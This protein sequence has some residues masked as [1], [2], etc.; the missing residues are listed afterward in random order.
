MCFRM[1]HKSLSTRNYFF[2]ITCCSE[3]YIYIYSPLSL[4]NIRS[5]AKIFVQH[6][7]AVF[8]WHL[9]NIRSASANGLRV[10]YNRS[11]SPGP[12]FSDDRSDTTTSKIPAV[13][14]E[15]KTQRLGAPTRNGTLQRFYHHRDTAIMPR[16]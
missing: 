15:N 6:F 2:T 14:I 11:K 3:V 8:L 16:R 5:Y 13:A 12:F 4:L 10:F 1:D 7:C 9:N